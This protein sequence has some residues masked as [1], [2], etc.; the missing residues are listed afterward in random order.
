MLL[1]VGRGGILNN[2][3]LFFKKAI[4]LYHCGKHFQKPAPEVNLF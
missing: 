4:Y 2:G 1:L 3:K